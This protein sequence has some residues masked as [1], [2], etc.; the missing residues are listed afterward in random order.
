V[1]K[2]E[3]LDRIV[4]MRDYT[5]AIRK[6]GEDQMAAALERTAELDA[7]ERDIALL[8]AAGQQ[9]GATQAAETNESMRAKNAR[10]ETRERAT[11]AREKSV[12]KGEQDLDRERRSFEKEMAR[13]ERKIAQEVDDLAKTRA[14]EKDEMKDSEATKEGKLKLRASENELELRWV[15]LK[16][17]EEEYER[18]GRQVRN[19]GEQAMFGEKMHRDL[20]Q[21]KVKELKA[22]IEGEKA[23]SRK[24]QEDLDDALK[25]VEDDDKVPKPGHASLSKRAELTGAEIVKARATIS[26][27]WNAIVDAQQDLQR[28]EQELARRG[29]AQVEAESATDLKSSQLVHLEFFKDVM[30]GVMVDVKEG[31][32]SNTA[33]EFDLS[34]REDALVRSQGVLELQTAEMKLEYGRLQAL[35]A[36]LSACGSWSWDRGARSGAEARQRCMR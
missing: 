1:S 3:L 8:E 18:R 19:L 6:Q 36:R 28:R 20:H 11:K 2:K 13:R 25:Q 33:W 30:E 24:A 35:E 15:E 7:R 21:A 23:K 9:H 12:E 27:E 22:E 26:N 10:M 4:K 5:L 17:M 34:G 31:R 29:A 16:T 14:R 32:T